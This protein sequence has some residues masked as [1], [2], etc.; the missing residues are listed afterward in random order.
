[1]RYQGKITT[2]KDQKGFGFVTTNASGEK[3]FF[4]IKSFPKHSKRPVEGDKITYE[5]IKDK[6]NRIKAEN[7]RYVV[8][9]TASDNVSKSISIEGSH[10]KKILLIAVALLL[11]YLFFNAPSAFEK[12]DVT[13]PIV[14]KSFDKSDTIIANAFSNHQSNLQIS[15]QGVVTKLLPDDNS[16]SRHQKF[17]IKLSS[18]Q[19]LLVAHNIDLA[20][21]INSLRQGDS[22]QFYGEYEWNG[23]GGVL[24][25]THRDPK[26]SHVDGWLEH[27]GQKYQ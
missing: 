24:H 9:N 1:M 21:K 8:D 5:L 18:G 7:I 23:K 10:M 13:S 26:G 3:A 27:E 4:H 25:W 14:D 20:P 15:G 2:W 6:D 19:T 11:A 12:N 22:V 17:I 16:G